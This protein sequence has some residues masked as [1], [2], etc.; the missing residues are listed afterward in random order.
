MTFLNR[1][2]TA[3]RLGTECGIHL[4][5]AGWSLSSSNATKNASGDYP[6]GTF[7][8]DTCFTLAFICE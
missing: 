3:K 4:T 7:I 2:A 5:D 6:P 8:L 1:K